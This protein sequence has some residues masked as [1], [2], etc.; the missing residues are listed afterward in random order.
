MPAEQ[1]RADPARSRSRSTIDRRVRVADWLAAQRAAVLGRWLTAAHAQ[2][3]HRA[4]PEAAIADHIPRLFDALVALL[5]RLPAG[6]ITAGAPLE[7]PE[8]LA[9]ARAHAAARYGQ[10]LGAPAILTE[11]RLL[12]QEIGRALRRGLAEGVAETEVLDAEPVVQEALDAGVLVALEALTRDQTGRPRVEEPVPQSAELLRLLI[13]RVEDYAIFLLDPEGRV[14]SWNTGAERITGYTAQEIMGRPYATFFTDEDCAAGRPDQL[15]RRARIDGRV[16]DVGWRLRKDGSRFWVSAVLTALYGARGRLHGYAKITRDLTERR[17]LEEQRLLSTALREVA[18][19]R[20]RA[21]AEAEAERHRLRDLFTQAP[22]AIAE[23]RG[24]EHEF[25]FANPQYVRLVGRR[26]PAELVGRPAR[27]ALPELEAQGYFELLDRVYRTGEPFVA[28]EALIKVDRRGDGTLEDLYLNFVYQPTRNAR[29]EVDG[30]FF[31]AVDVTPEVQARRRTEELA[32]A[33]AEE[34]ERFAAIF[35]QASAGIAQQDLEGRYVLVNDRF[36]EL[37]GQPRDELLQLRDLDLTHPDDRARN[38]ELLARL[39]AEGEG[40]SIEKRYVRPDGTEVWVNSAVSLVRDAG[41][42][43]RFALAVAHDVTDR[44]RAEAAL[45]LRSDLLEAAYEAIFAWEVS[46]GII[47]WNRGA[48]ELYG[49]AAAEALGR[50][51]RDLLGT[52]PEQV[53]AF[54]AALEREG[55][56]EGELT[57]TTKA[58]RRIT[59]AARLALVALDQGRCVLEV[60]RDVTEQRRAEQALRASEA[61]SVL[62]AEA[63]R[64]LGSSLDYETTLANFAK[65]AVPQV[66][67]WCAVDL[68]DERG[69]LRRLVVAHTNPNKVRLAHELQERYPPDPRLGTGP[70]HVVRT[71]QPELVSEIPDALLEHAAR[72]PAHLALL[73]GLGLRS[74]MV[75]PLRVREQVLGAITFVTAESGRRFRLEDLAVAEELASR[76]ALAIENARLYARAQEAIRTRDDF[77]AAAS[78]DLKNPLGSIRANAQLLL[79]MLERTGAVPPQRLSSALTSVISS[80]DQMVEQINELLDVARLRLGEPLPLERAPTDLVALARRAVAAHQAAAERHRLELH[81]DETQLVGDWDQAR[82]QR[83]LGNLLSNAI[84]Y[85]PA[86]GKI[87]ITVR[88]V[89]GEAVLAVRDEGIGIPATDLPKI[90]ERFERARNVVGRI[91]GSGIGLAVAKQIVEQHGGSI[92]V[93]SKEGAGS[94]FTVRLPLGA[95]TS[96]PPAMRRPAQA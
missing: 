55:R 32:A 10:G 43:A 77:L 37:V 81:T 2:P 51:S 94:T 71:G 61:R 79:R 96:G 48:E 69:V 26:D 24:P 27:Q 86:G 13:E 39:I 22:A 68:L 92:T 57:H 74:Y 45:R 88:R 47:L 1:R 28:R 58:G 67:D 80:A 49:Y 73:R 21:L 38:E 14:A 23:L 63:G 40:Y 76:A 12:R 25:V 19:A 93:A 6:Q 41:G 90:F 87:E 72:D 44:R 70:A 78:H 50:R 3:F 52:P 56:W 34:R 95:G 8:V 46:G 4:R 20:D 31:H 7:D 66:A 36:C 53:A 9:A 85:S 91:G 65:L 16:E 59:V 18:E 15:L 64:V 29:G 82:L 30:I 84:K 11:F 60:T 42:T 33:L 62:L 54:M 83:V 35:S 75:V 5:Q 89:G 17:Q